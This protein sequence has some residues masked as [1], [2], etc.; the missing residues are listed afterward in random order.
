MTI[1]YPA[2]PGPYATADDLGGYWRALSSGEQAQATV[3]LAAA[4]DR[5]NEVPGAQNFV[6]TAAHWVA[7]DMAKRAMIGGGGEKSESQA[8]AGMTVTRAFTNPMGDLYVTSK[9][10]NRLRGRFG[11]SAGSVV[12]TSNVRVPREPWNFQPTPEWGLQANLV[13][14]MLL[15]P[16]AVSL[17]VGA[18]RHLMV[19]AATFF[20]YEERTDYALFKSSDT[21]IATVDNDGLVIARGVGTAT[22]TAT[23][24]GFTD[25]C[26]VTVS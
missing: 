20:E 15:V 3:L 24:E 19:L 4:S 12:L 18:E 2:Y 1:T 16:E 8:M 11:Q 23:Y 17:T 21:T 5:I 9:E 10:I 13:Q 25:T 26:T 6:K 7:L 14:W 22:I